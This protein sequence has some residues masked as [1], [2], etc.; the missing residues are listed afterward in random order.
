MR[1]AI[2]ADHRGF[3]MKMT[4]ARFLK[5][6]RHRVLDVGTYNEESCDYPEY[7]WRVAQAVAQGK[8]DRG[9]VIC[10]TGIGQ[11]IVAN[12]VR[13]VRAALVTDSTVARLSRTHNDSN[14]LVLSSLRSNLP[15]A[16]RIVKVWLKTPAG[17]GRH[18]RRVKMIKHFERLGS[19][20]TRAGGRR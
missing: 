20:A 15:Q 9:L 5:K 12:K 8:A 3:R 2:G 13:G 17:K 18:A 10:H 1:V 19:K 16:K 7:G 4:L 14:V 11:S 6:C